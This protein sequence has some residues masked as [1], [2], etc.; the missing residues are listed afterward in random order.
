MLGAEA[1][2]PVRRIGSN[3]KP[4]AESQLVGDLVDQPTTSMG[5]D[6]GFNKTQHENLTQT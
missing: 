1:G 3:I 2:T 5:L 6:K 4:L